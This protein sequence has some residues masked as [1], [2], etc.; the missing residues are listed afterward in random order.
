MASAMAREVILRFVRNNPG[1]T[2]DQVVERLSDPVTEHLTRET[3][4]QMLVEGV[5]WQ[6]MDRTYHA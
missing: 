5:V 3:L 2:E 1:L 4:A 6:K